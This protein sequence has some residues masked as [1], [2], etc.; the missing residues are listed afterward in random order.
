M[1]QLFILVFLSSAFLS[2]AQHRVRLDTH[3]NKVGYTI[4]DDKDQIVFKIEP[5]FEYIAVNVESR[6]GNIY[7]GEMYY[8]LKMCCDTEYI[9]VP[10]DP[11]NP[12]IVR[13]DTIITDQKTIVPNTLIIAKK[14]GNW[15]LLNL[16]G[17][18]AMPFIYD[19]ISTLS[20]PHA[21]KN[22]PLFLLVR[23]H[24]VSVLSQK[25]D[26]V[27]SEEIYRQYYP[28]LSVR[29]QM[30]LLEIA[31][32]ND[33]LIVQQSG[34]FI[35]TTIHVKAKTSYV[36]I[37]GVKRKQMVYSPEQ[38]YSEYF[39]RGGKFNVL[40][41]K[42]NHLLLGKWHNKINMRFKSEN[43]FEKPLWMDI[44]KRKSVMSAY[45]QYVIV[46]EPVKVDFV[47]EPIKAKK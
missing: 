36:S 41:L 30:H 29:E 32:F 8:D 19:T 43:R 23:H 3:N 45:Y 24:R 15:G 21:S 22:G 31:L 13:V 9:E 47:P 42:D 26:T 20:N 33:Y 6:I 35:D 34:S 28:G 44:T 2:Q 7:L 10:I 12:M 5:N 25:R 4:W 39:F 1:K 18:E 40:I 11:N 17:S 38:N 27:L 14:N 16:D 46:K 37:K